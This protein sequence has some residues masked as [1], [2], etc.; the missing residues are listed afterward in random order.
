MEGYDMEGVHTRNIGFVGLGTVGKHMAANLLR[1][2]HR[3]TV[4]DG[5][6]PEV[7][8]LVRDG[9]KRAESPEETAKGRDLVIVVLPEQEGEKIISGIFAGI[10]PDTILIDM[11]T[12]SMRATEKLARAA[13]KQQIPFLEAPVWGSK[14]NAA[15]G[16]LTI[17]VGGDKEHLARCREALSCMGI[18]II[19]VGEVGDATRLKMVVDLMQAEL[20]QALA[21]GV[22]LG[23]KLGFSVEKI[24]EVL[25]SGGLAS[26]LFHTKGR[27]LGRGDF[28]RNLA[29]KYV[30]DELKLADETA[31]QEALD[32][33]AA[34][35]V[36]EVFDRAVESG[37]GEEDFSAVVKL[38]RK[39]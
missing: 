22:T 29:L 4:F 16:M 28:S 10:E 11:G 35:R 34:K 33:P 13:E 25:D 27:S 6:Q 21:E 18:N 8:E 17:L 23:E 36:L 39:P 24:L 12:H 38:L 30:R 9:A 1:C 2:G 5:Q 31:S 20:M 26:P 14:E 3:L 15:N 32:L 19:P 7:E 37:Y